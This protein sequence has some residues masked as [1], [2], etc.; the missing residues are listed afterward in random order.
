MK[1]DTT[2]KPRNS[3]AEALERPS[4]LKL[5]SSDLVGILKGQEGAL[6]DGWAFERG[7]L[8]RD[9]FRRILGKMRVCGST[10]ELRSSLDRQTG[11]VG[12]P[13]VHAANFCGQHSICPVCAGRVQDRRGQRFQDPIKQ[14]AALYPYAY[15]L[16]ATVPPNPSWRDQVGA[17]IDGWQS[18]RR[19]GQRRKGRRSQRSAGEW[20]KVRAGVAKIELKR[21]SGSGLPHCHYHALV[22]T[23]APLNYRVWD[24]SQKHL[25]KEQRRALYT[26]RGPN[27]DMVA[28][29]KI[30][31]EWH[32]ATGGA[33]N[34][35]VDPIKYRPYD[36]QKGRTWEEAVFD[37][38]RE[39]L[40]Y[41]TKFDSSPSRG[42]ERLF[43]S[44][45]VGIRDAT[46]QRRLFTTYGD[47]R[48]VPGNDF[49]GGAPHISE[50]PLIF[51]SHWRGLDYSPLEERSR[52]IFPNTDASPETSARL[53]RLNRVQ[54]QI[55][56]MRSSIIRARNEYWETGML[57]PAFYSRR[58][59]L[60]DGAFIDNLETLELPRWVIER[61]NS[62]ESWEQWLDE[63][64]EAGRTWYANVKERIEDAGRE[65]MDG[66]REEQAAQRR[67]ELRSVLASSEYRES[68][69]ELFR[70]TKIE[71]RERVAGPP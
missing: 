65:R 5:W 3:P 46:Y 14:A 33:V 10:V 50:K 35:R 36:R 9:D 21:G 28:A 57:R 61:P 40:K 43:A 34:F 49:E 11:E 52:P 53:T 31:A 45:F 27:G 17:L 39:V 26:V 70:R 32:A 24:A 13:K 71:S 67:I 1:T 37:Q 25:P 18:F 8:T 41:A 16:T 48:R 62:P 30:S 55:R 59:Y 64:M 15:M 7:K 12:A 47:F 69:V 4:K 44:D 19:M 2:P 23:D 58:E 6:F 22:F 42:A 29:S 63:V 66:T 60:E 38:A 54:G 56:R 68:V 20:G 51:E